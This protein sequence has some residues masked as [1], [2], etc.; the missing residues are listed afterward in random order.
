MIVNR[1]LMMMI[2][3]IQKHTKER[4]GRK[5]MIICIQSD[6]EY[7]E[8][9]R[10]ISFYRSHEHYEMVTAIT[11]KEGLVQPKTATESMKY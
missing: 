1:I 8:I 11:W 6:S 7:I 9:T 5:K 4:E 3:L 2:M 10:T